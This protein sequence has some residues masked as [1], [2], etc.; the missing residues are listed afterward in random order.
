LAAALE[1]LGGGELITIDPWEIPHYWEG[2]K[3]A[4]YIQWIPKRSDDAFEEVRSKTFDLICIDSEHTYRTCMREVILFEPLLKTGGYLVFH[5][6]VLHDGVGAV[7]EQIRGT[8]RFEVVTMDTPRKFNSM[9]GVSCGTTIARKIAEGHGD[10]PYSAEKA[11]WPERP[12]I[13]GE[14][15]VRRAARLACLDSTRSF[16]FLAT[17]RLWRTLRHKVGK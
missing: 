17:R 11:L 5:D 6:S 7:V 8:H 3:L 16:W 10:L 15:W 2:S 13:Y 4:E 12:P 9:E 14:S 1:K